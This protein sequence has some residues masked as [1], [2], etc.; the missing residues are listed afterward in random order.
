MWW[1]RNLPFGVAEMSVFDNLLTL[2]FR[3]HRRRL[4]AVRAASQGFL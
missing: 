3:G 4:I 1:Q 2:I